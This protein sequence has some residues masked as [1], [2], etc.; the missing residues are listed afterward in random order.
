MDC[1]ESLMQRR[2]KKNRAA[3]SKKHTGPGIKLDKSL[4]SLPP[5][6]VESHPQAADDFSVDGYVDSSI[7]VS[8]RTAAPALDVGTSSVDNQGK[9]RDVLQRTMS[10]QWI[11][12]LRP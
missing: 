5:E 12:V 8:S 1:H 2:R 6:E 9:H 4:P 3:T 11:D 7:E 10:V